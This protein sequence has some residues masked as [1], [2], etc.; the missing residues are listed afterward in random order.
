MP[1]NLY[2]H[3]ALVQTRQIGRTAND[4]RRACRFNFLDLSIALNG[5]LFVNAAI[6]VLAAAVFFK[7]HI[8][9]TEI[10][11]AYQLLS[12]LLGTTAASVLFALAL[13]DR[14]EVGA[15]L[16]RHAT[17]FESGPRRKGG[18]AGPSEAWGRH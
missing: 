16:W 11:Q 6:L 9:V 4:K 18:A 7:R 3:S 1:H 15:G 12:P 17:A 8:I 10:Q 2:L 14:G 13:P 5:A